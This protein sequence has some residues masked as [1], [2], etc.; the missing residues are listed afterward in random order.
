[1]PPDV[2]GRLMAIA[3]G[4]VLERAVG[5]PR[6]CRREVVWSV[7]LPSAM[8]DP[9]Q[10]V[11]QAVLDGDAQRYAELVDRYQQ[12][13]RRLAFGLLGND[14]DAKD[15]SQEAFVKAYQS[16]RRFRGE[17]KFSTWLYRIVVNV[18][19]DAYRR[20]ARQPMV[21]AQVGVQ[22]ESQEHGTF[23]VDVEDPTASP[24]DRA[25]NQE[26]SRQLSGAINALPQRQRTAFV[27][28]QLHGMPLEDVAAVMRCRLG[29]VKSHVFRATEHLR[30]RLRPWVTEEGS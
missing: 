18:C 21:A 4:Y 28:H 24:R 6:V 26:L 16:L 25:A 15:A 1:M 20:R 19:Q 22:D 23:F 30:V 9:D 10:E 11:I 14:E 8:A 29:T 12:P 2:R 5:L 17:G 7:I 27:L 13:M 3:A